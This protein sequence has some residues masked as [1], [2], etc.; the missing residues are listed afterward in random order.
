MK[1]SRVVLARLLQLGC[2]LAAF[3][4]GLIGQEPAVAAPELRSFLHAPLREAQ[5]CWEAG[6]LACAERILDDLASLS[7]LTSHEAAH[8]L[9]TRAFMHVERGHRSEARTVYEAIV[10]LPGLPDDLAGSIRGEL[11]RIY[12]ADG[13]YREALDAFDGSVAL[14]PDIERRRLRETIEIRMAGGRRIRDVEELNGVAADIVAAA[15]AAHA[16]DVARSGDPAFDEW[17]GESG[18]F[19]THRGRDCEQALEMMQSRGWRWRIFFVSANERAPRPDVFPQPPRN[20]DLI[21]EVIE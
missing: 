15:E 19:V 5:A 18:I 10:R 7:D 2:A 14:A 21:H 12:L 6:D 9:S 20:L 16:C 8:V 3:P 4:C 11:A 1:R 17:T 13:R